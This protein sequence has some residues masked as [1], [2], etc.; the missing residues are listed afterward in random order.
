MDT[1]CFL[2]EDEAL[3]SNLAHQERKRKLTTSPGHTTNKTGVC[4]STKSPHCA[5][6]VLMIALGVD[7]HVMNKSILGKIMEEM[8]EYYIVYK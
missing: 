8:R 7:M 1:R 4:L 2:D 3:Y 5:V 6:L